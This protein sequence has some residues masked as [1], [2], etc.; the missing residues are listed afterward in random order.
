MKNTLETE[1]KAL[2]TDIYIQ[3]VL[4]NR[5]QERNARKDL[6]KLKRL[7]FSKQKILNRFDENSEL[8]FLNGNLKKF[9]KASPDLILIAKKSLYYNEATSGI[10]DPRILEVLEANG[11]KISFGD[12]NFEQLFLKSLPKIK[13]TKLNDD[14]KIKGD[15][16]YFGRKMDFNGIA[17]GYITDLAADFLK[18][19]G[20]ENFLIDSG[21]DM[22]LEGFNNENRAWKI[23]LEDYP[24]EKMML[25]LSNKAIATSGISRKQWKVKEKKFHHLI[26]PSNPS[27]YSFNLKSV[28]VIKKTAEEADVF[29]KTLFLM[30][31]SRG[32]KYSNL[33]GFASIFLDQK[34]TIWLSDKIKPYTQ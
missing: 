4:D 19:R 9:H 34:N 7:Y 5:D 11:Y 8:S 20:W 18:K 27:Q 25:S 2:G 26:N 1:F 29:A 3:L 15:K 10:F 14:L 32:V 22:H 21:G 23:S 13:S 16:V 31:K 12:I 6:A 28:T 17:K 24:E 30:G 33:H